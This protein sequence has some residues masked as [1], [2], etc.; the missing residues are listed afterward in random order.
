MIS[1]PRLASTAGRP[2][3]RTWPPSRPPP[4]RGPGLFQVARANGE[5]AIT[6]IRRLAGAERAPGSRL[7]L[8]ATIL[9]GLLAAGLF[10]RHLQRPV[11]VRVRGQAA[12]DSRP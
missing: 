5:T 6:N 1:G 10:V 12:V 3:S 2:T 9:L 11:Q 8:A 7:V 4:P